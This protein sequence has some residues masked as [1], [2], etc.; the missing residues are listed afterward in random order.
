MIA[1]IIFITLPGA[2][3]LYQWMKFEMPSALYEKA[4][5]ILEFASIGLAIAVCALPFFLFKFPAAIVIVV[6]MAVAS[7][8]WLVAI[9]IFFCGVGFL[10]ASENGFINGSLLAGF[11]VVP[12]AIV[13]YLTGNRFAS[14]YSFYS[15]IIKSETRATQKAE[16]NTSHFI[17][18]LRKTAL[19]C[20]LIIMFVELRPLE[21]DAI[22]LIYSKE[23]A[24]PRLFQATTH[25]SYDAYSAIENYGKD[26]LPLALE[27][28]HQ[29]FQNGWKES[30][31]LEGRSTSSNVSELTEVILEIG[32]AE[33]LSQLG[34]NQ[35]VALRATASH[36]FRSTGGMAIEELIKL[37]A[38]PEIISSSNSINSQEIAQALLQFPPRETIPLLMIWQ[39]TNKEP[40]FSNKSDFSRRRDFEF[41]T[42]LAG[43]GA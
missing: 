25:D 6:F 16:G 31:D 2:F 13:T 32:E 19:Y 12:I 1:T 29:E 23:K 36:G 26:A 3:A 38:I 34:D 14:K 11:I 41:S 7:T 17:G 28:L 10:V 33:K 30:V 9:S 22:E 27:M 5:K 8:R 39:S 15:G 18:S 4:N 37:K 43:Y 42:E 24:L 21:V 40:L 35:K 20:S